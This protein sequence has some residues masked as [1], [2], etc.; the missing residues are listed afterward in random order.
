MTDQSKSSSE[1][2]SMEE[3]DARI[4]QLRPKAE[5][6]VF[7]PPAGWSGNLC[8]GCKIVSVSPK[9]AINGSEALVDSNGYNAWTAPVGE[10]VPETVLDLGSAV[11]F[12]RIVV[13]VRHTESRGTGG[14]NN[15]VRRIGVSVSGSAE[16]PW[17][18]IETGE[19]EGP[20]PMCFKTAEGQVCTFIDNTEPT[21][22]EI[23]P[24]EARFVR[25][26][27]LEAHWLSYAMEEW[28]TSVSI[29][30]FMLYFSVS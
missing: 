11:V 23:S 7:V 28:K 19:I 21:I 8:A 20:V 25:L 30:G 2:L 27:L 1:I 10:G 9:S 29:S 3:V 14:G 26:R 18:D 16:G 13:F 4:D 15:A 12:D 24:V 17:K 5:D 6:F 22:L